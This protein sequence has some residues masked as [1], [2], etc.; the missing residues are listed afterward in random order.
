MPV[1]VYCMV[2]AVHEHG[3]EINERVARDGAACRRVNDA[4]LDG[5]AEILRN[6]AAENL[7]LEHE[8]FAA[9]QRLEDDLAIT[10]LAAPA[11]LLL[12]ASLDFGALRDRLLVGNLRRVERDPY[13][14][15]LLQLVYH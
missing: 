11:R 6:R 1:G 4:L 12:V 13:A 9:R 10:E 7:V 5:R 3:F 2:G 14:V 8:A 15:T